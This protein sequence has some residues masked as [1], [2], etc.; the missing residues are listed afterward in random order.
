MKH[1]ETE[2]PSR[3]AHIAR[4]SLERNIVR[5][6]SGSYLSAGQGHFRGLWTRDF[7]FAARALLRLG[8][9]DVVRDHLRALIERRRRPDALVPRLLDSITPCFTRVVREIAAQ[10]VP[11]LPRPAPICDPLV[12]EYRSEHGAEAIDSNALVLLRALDYVD[13]TGDRAFFTAHE[14][15]LIEIFRF[16]DLRLQD[17]L[18]RQQAFTDW[19]DSVRRRGK[20]LYT[21]LLYAAVAKRLVAHPGFGVREHDA[22][23][24]E[25]RIFAT[26]H[27]PQTG[28]L[29]SVEGMP[30]VSL[31]GL[32]LAIELGLLE[33]SHAALYDALTQSPLWRRDGVPGSNT[34]PRWPRSAIAATVGLVGLSGYHDVLHWSWLTAAALGTARRMGDADTAARIEAHLL[35]LL[36]RDDCVYEVYAP[37]PP[38]AAW[39]SRLYAS[40]RDFAWGAGYA[41][42]ALAP[43]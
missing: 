14:P 37:E 9:H 39:R 23:A 18:L 22:L 6:P 35:R 3:G 21:N 31:D 32:L 13:A 24:L 7:C 15:A 5:L 42:L 40:E 27:D 33:S 28:L 38:H 1:D 26:F 8:H 36:E 30:H 12:A 25:R 17:G 41:V 20:T 10:R 11:G 2:H 19:Q 43:R 34:F 4:R 16:Y 29:R